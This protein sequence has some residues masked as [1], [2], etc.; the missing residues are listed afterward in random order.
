[1]F[2][3][4]ELKRMLEEFR[5]RDSES[6]LLEFK[7][8]N[9]DY[10]FE[11]LGKYFS[12]LSNEANLK[13][14]SSAWIIFGVKNNPPREIVGSNY[15]NN[16]ASIESIKHEVAVQTNGITFQEIYELDLPEGRVLMF[17]IPAAPAG[18]PTS[19][20]GHYYGR[21]G[22]SL[23]PLAVHKLEAIRGQATQKDW[24]AVICDSATI[25][26]LDGT[27]IQI[28]REKFSA[29]HRASEFRDEIDGWD[30]ATFLDKAKLTRNGQITRTAIILLGKVEATHH[31]NPHPAQ[32]T[33]KLDTEEEAY[34]HFGPPFLLSV[35]EVYGKIRNIKFKLQPFNQLLPIELTKY[36]P[37]IILEA[38]NNCIAHQDY[39]QNA[40]II[41]TERV[42]GIVL[43]NS[44]GFFDGTIEDYVL[45][46]RTPGRYRNQFLTQAMVNLDMIDTMGMGIRRMFVE[47]R[48]RYFPMP[49]YDLSNPNQVQ[50]TIYG[51]LI[52]ENYSRIL[53]EKADLDLSLVISLD[54][55]QKKQSVDKKTVALLR[56]EKLVEGRYPN[57]FV[58]AKIAAVT[59]DKAQYIKNR[60]FD[61]EHYEKLILKFIQKYGSATRKD[62]DGLILDKLPDVLD[63]ERKKNKVMNLL[64][65]MRKNGLIENKGSSAAPKWTKTK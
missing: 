65:K 42:D 59:G 13:A 33:W 27:A 32:I 54:K 12:A 47:Q 38:L 64:S 63:A 31:V 18:I 44:G 40:R 51:K 9:N 34:Q 48:K 15:R 61:D 49:E 41:V 53:I 56:K 25:N 11:N 3:P 39:S 45:R 28:A 26:D 23:V 30:I 6:E 5:Q 50:M 20:K 46:G 52:D 2:N 21:D 55:I 17:Q 62:I 24:S 29:K 22:E 7:E 16:R 1:M 58:S 43:L 8:A 35:E 57:V 14:T 19:W 60:A 37:R 4:E 36:E 10:S